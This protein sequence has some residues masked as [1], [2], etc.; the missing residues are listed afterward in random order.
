MIIIDDYSPLWGSG[1]DGGGCTGVRGDTSTYSVQFNPLLSTFY[2]LYVTLM[3]SAG[4]PL[5]RKTFSD[6]SSYFFLFFYH[7]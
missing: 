2:F 6:Y 7:I 5:V 4:G 3:T 1:S